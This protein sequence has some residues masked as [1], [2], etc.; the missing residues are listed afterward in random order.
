MKSQPDFFMQ[1]KCLLFFF[2]VFSNLITAELKDHL[3]K[4]N[5]K[6]DLFQIKNIDF[7]YM[8]NLDERPQ[9]FE[10][11]L[12]ELFPYGITPYRFSAINGWNLSLDTINQLGIKYESWMTNSISGTCYLEENRGRPLHEQMREGRIYFSFDVALGAIGCALSHFSV[13]QDALDSGY[14]TIWV[15]EDDIEVIQN[16]HL[17]SDRIDELDRAVGKGNW[18]ILFTDQDTKGQDGN[19]VPC[20]S[21]T[22]RPNFS[23]LQPSKFSERKNITPHLRQ[24][25][26][27]YGSYSMIIR[28]SGMKKILDFINDYQL[29][30]P[31]DMEYTLPEGISLYTVRQDI[32]STLPRA[33]SDNGSPNYKI[34]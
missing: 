5:N 20:F 29:F 1:T 4:A 17:L 27:R 34:E 30:L 32:V 15:M 22:P 3:R 6:T 31:Y 7:I 12:Q 18:D 24:I 9:K 26:A 8:I 33:P 10:K 28:R 11:S 13:L 2:L 14:Q 21:H 19:Y 23:P 16:P 25:G